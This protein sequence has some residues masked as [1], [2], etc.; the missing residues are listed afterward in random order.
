MAVPKMVN[1]MAFQ[2]PRRLYG[3]IG[4]ELLAFS[5]DIMELTY[6]GRR[7]SLAVS[8]LGESG[9]V[10]LEWASTE[11]PEGGATTLA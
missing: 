9:T 8:V 3:R 2:M 6:E 7:I 1:S 5:E 4:A 10:A 11:V